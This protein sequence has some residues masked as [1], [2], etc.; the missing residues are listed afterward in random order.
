MQVLMQ[1]LLACTYLVDA[2]ADAARKY[3][4]SVCVP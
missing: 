2:G 1:V 4:A 3:T